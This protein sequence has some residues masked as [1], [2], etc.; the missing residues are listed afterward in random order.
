MQAHTWSRKLRVTLVFMERTEGK[1]T[2]AQNASVWT[3]SVFT[4]EIPVRFWNMMNALQMCRT[5]SVSVLN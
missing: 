5:H 2:E 3:F 4:R 1:Q